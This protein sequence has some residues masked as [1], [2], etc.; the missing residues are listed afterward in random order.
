MFLSYKSK[1][2]IGYLLKS[3]IIYLGQVKNKKAREAADL[4][5][6]VCRY[7]DSLGCTFRLS[8]FQG[9]LPQDQ[10]HQ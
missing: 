3:T 1:L 6:Q 9:V 4:K 8:A 10:Y 2:N 5:C 7:Y